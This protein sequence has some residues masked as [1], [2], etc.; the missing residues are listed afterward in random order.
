MRAFWWTG[1]FSY[2]PFTP[3][4]TNAFKTLSQA[5]PVNAIAHYK[6]FPIKDAPQ[7]SDSESQIMMTLTI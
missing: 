6:A 2:D 7:L 5:Q 1:L 4:W 3:A